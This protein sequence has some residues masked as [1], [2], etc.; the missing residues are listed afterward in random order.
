MKGIFATVE[1]NLF[2][3]AKCIIGIWLFTAISMASMLNYDL[4]YP[5]VGV[6]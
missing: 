3:Y 4:A 1:S 5:V 2:R 6:A